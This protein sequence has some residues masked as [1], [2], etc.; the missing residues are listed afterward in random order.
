MG[1][2]GGAGGGANKASNAVKGIAILQG[3]VSKART[4]ML[5]SAYSYLEKKSM[6]EMTNEE[7]M[8]RAATMDELSKRGRMIND[9]ATG[10]SRLT[11]E[12]N[13]VNIGE[14]SYRVNSMERRSFGGDAVEIADADVYV[15]GRWVHVKN[16]QI[17]INVGKEYRKK[18][19]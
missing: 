18:K 8:V 19:K 9:Y 11:K 4:D 7:K 2:R 17:S 13:V 14:K 3:A 5:I 10:E 16:D 1:G 15:K 6:R 12:R